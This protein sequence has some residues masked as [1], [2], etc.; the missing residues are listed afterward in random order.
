M[1]YRYTATNAA[2][3]P[4]PSTCELRVS[5]TLP[6]EGYEEVGVF[7]VSGGAPARAIADFKEQ[8]GAQACQAGGDLVVAEVNGGGQIVRAVVFAKRRESASSGST[9]AN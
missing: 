4:K 9:S 6:A 2:R 7:E 3:P 8:Y 1:Q 5:A